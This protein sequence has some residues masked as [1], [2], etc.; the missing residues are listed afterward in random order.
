MQ[1]IQAVLLGIIQGITEWLPI[2]SQGQTLLAMMNWLCISPEVA[3][4]YSLIL[5]LG[6]MSA[7][8][9]K[10]RHEL[11][12]MLKNLDSNLTRAMIITTLF[13]GITG[14]PLYLLIRE[15]FTGG[16]EATIIIGV[17]LIATGLLL[18]SQRSGTKD[19]ESITIPDMVLLGLAQG[20]AILPGIS[21]S[22]TTITV[23]LMRNVR[24]DAALALSF[25][26]SVPAVLGAVIIDHSYA[27]LP[28]GT[29]AT[30]LL[31]SFT[32]GYLTMDL[33]IKFARK[34]NFSKFCIAMGLLTIMITVIL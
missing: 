26:I 8:I 21:R 25:M 5:H 22:G 3:L 19:I 10:F 23:L 9:V 7:V 15:T 17:L 6:T 16:R 14:L 11:I 28:I 31:A 2:S 1:T 24:Q 34:I 13:G 27:A 20:L 30:M 4:S 12:G 18:R 33:L 29:S 32:A